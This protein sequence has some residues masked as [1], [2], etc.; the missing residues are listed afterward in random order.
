MLAVV[1]GARRIAMI[2]SS[3][4]PSA[5]RSLSDSGSTAARR[6]T[7]RVVRAL[8]AAG[9]P[10]RSP[11]RAP[12][13]SRPRSARRLEQLVP[14]ELVQL[15]LLGA[16]QR[17]GAVPG[18]V[19][20]VRQQVRA[21]QSPTGPGGAQ[22]GVDVRDGRQE[23]VARSLRGRRGA[24]GRG[25][26]ASRILRD[27]LQPGVRGDQLLDPLPHEGDGHPLVALLEPARRRRSPPRSAGGAPCRPA[28]HARLGCR[29]SPGSAVARRRTRRCPGRAPR[30]SRSA[31]SRPARAPR[32]AP[33]RSAP[34]RT[35]PAGSRGAG[36]R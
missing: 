10:S 18:P 36:G 14:A 21:D 17:L 20:E 30:P 16:V 27:A 34:A 4:S 26:R 13:A 22:R 33:S 7:K 28:R 24:P 11:S 12:R 9:A 15:A 25:R 6:A 32:R 2:S 23:L 3:V 31:R 29:R 19:A 35:G 1:L 8:L 5:S